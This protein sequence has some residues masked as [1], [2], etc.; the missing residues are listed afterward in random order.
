MVDEMLSCNESIYRSQFEIK[1]DNLFVDEN[2]FTTYGMIENLAQTAAAGIAITYTGNSRPDEGFLGALSN[3][4]I[5]GSAHIGDTITSEVEKIVE[6]GKLY[7]MKGK[8][9]NQGKLIFECELNL[10]AK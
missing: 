9:F 4:N 10:A 2:E 8:C 5:V 1:T 6:I 3:M 7:K